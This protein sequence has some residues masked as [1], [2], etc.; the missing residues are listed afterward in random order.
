MR[1][2]ELMQIRWWEGTAVLLWVRACVLVLGR[3]GYKSCFSHLLATG[4]WRNYPNSLSFSFLIHKMKCLNSKCVWLQQQKNL[5]ELLRGLVFWYNKSRG[6]AFH[7]Q[8][9]YSWMFSGSSLF[10]YFCFDV[11]SM[12]A[13]VFM[14]VAL[15]LQMAVAPSFSHQHF[16]HEGGKK[17]TLFMSSQYKAS[18]IGG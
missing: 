2:G 3:Y 7:G 14:L 9:S 16:S 17:C 1:R 12:E 15:W 4:V 18:A 6:W 13:S 11:L 10:P 5:S 8:C